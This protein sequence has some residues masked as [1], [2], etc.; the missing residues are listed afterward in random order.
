MSA[1]NFHNARALIHINKWLSGYRFYP[2]NSED[3]NPSGKSIL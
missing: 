2:L 1:G 3:F